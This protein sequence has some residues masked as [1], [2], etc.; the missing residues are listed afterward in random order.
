MT[1]PVKIWRVRV[2]EERETEFLIVAPDRRAAE[3][4]A[5]ELAESSDSDDWE[6]TASG[7]DCHSHETE[8]RWIK[9]GEPVWVGGPAGQFR[10]WPLPPPPEPS[11][12]LPGLEAS[13]G[14]A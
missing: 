1:A 5:Y 3:A 2:T 8:A 12:P 13:D 6:P 7:W 4:T 14:A 11:P 10:R 9:E